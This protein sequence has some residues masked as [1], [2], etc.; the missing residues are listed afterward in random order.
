MDF[1][2]EVRP[3]RA[4]C[5]AHLP[6]CRAPRDT[7]P[8][9]DRNLRKVGVQRPVAIPMIDDD[10]VP[11]SRVAPPRRDH[12]PRVC[13]QDR[14]TI[15]IGNIYRRMVPAEALGD[16]AKCRPDEGT[17]R[18]DCSSVRREHICK[19]RRA[20]RGFVRHHPIWHNERLA[21]HDSKGL[22]IRERVKR[23]VHDPLRIRLKFFRDRV[24][25]VTRLYLVHNACDWWDRDFLAIFNFLPIY[26]WICPLNTVD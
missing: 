5:R 17:R 12:R 26:V 20:R 2:V 25:G 6:D 18:R 23:K 13:R 24:N 1:K 22:V 9:D 11:I 16:P 7:L 3:G 15:M 10:V 4:A 14:P 21:S 8:H 19:A